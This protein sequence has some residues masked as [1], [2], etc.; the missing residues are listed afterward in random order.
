MATSHGRLIPFGRR[1][2]VGI[3][4]ASALLALLGCSLMS[5]TMTAPFEPDTTG[6]GNVITGIT[7]S[8][9]VPLGLSV[10][11]IV[12]IL[13]TA[14]GQLLSHRRE[15]MRIKRNGTTGNNRRPESGPEEPSQD[16]PRGA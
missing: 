12:L 15:M 2:W 4:T 3:A 1:A 5:P 10:I 14:F 9:A 8:E 7:I 6:D 11:V 16:Q 13:Y